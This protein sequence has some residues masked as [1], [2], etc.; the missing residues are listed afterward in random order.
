MLHFSH[1]C[2]QSVA[3]ENAGRCG[4]RGEQG[5]HLTGQ[6][7]PRYRAGFTKRAQR[8]HW[9]IGGV[10]RVSPFAATGPAEEARLSKT[11]KMGRSLEGFIR[12]H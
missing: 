7:P 12:A 2:R 5:D 11:I 1:H 10:S 3:F 9:G 6:P 4:W 8:A